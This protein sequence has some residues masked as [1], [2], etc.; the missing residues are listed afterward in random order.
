MHPII[1][2]SFHVKSTSSYKKII[3]KTIE[4]NKIPII[5]PGIESSKIF[6]NPLLKTNHFVLKQFSKIR[7]GTKINKIISGSIPS[8]PNVKYSKIDFFKIF[9]FCNLL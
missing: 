1:K 7:I 9:Y 3:F 4:I 2:E 6:F 8:T 5:T